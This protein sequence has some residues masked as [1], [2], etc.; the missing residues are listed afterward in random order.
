MTGVAM[1]GG[2]G[3]LG[4]HVQCALREQDVVAGDIPVGSF[5]DADQARQAMDGASRFI[6]LAGVNRGTDEEVTAGNC[7]FAEQAADVLRT[8]DNPP[9]VVVYANSIQSSLD[10]TYGKAK[11]QAS[12]IL[13]AAAHSIGAEFIDIAFPNLFGEHGRPFY[14]SVVATFCHI[15]AEGGTPEVIEDRELTLLHAQDAADVLTGTISIS[16]M[17]A[18]TTLETVTGLR[19]R[20]A[21]IAACY[22]RGDIPDISTDVERNLFNTY[23]SYAPTLTTGIA[24]TPHS[25][26]RG[27]FFEI[28]RAHGGRSQSSFSVTNPGFRR[29]D[30]FH[31]RKIE[32]FIVLAGQARMTLRK[33]GT[34]ESV[35]ID[36]TGDQPVAVDMPTMWTHAIT[37]TGSSPLY[38]AFWINELYDPAHPDTIPE[39]A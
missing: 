6:H 30:H 14:N 22:S 4:W 35:T 36:V 5:F 10:N 31:R 11:A 32:R 15:L 28:M 8:V 29:G 7:L 27:T 24:L 37:N 9:A 12:E 3:F 1:T 38:T 19:D 20:L 13:R 26:P 34:A 39:V 33:Y 17:S 23:R 18:L 21:S 25:D 2:D 16:Q